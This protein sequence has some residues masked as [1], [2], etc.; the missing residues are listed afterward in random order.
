MNDQLCLSTNNA[1]GS[2]HE[3]IQTDSILGNFAAATPPS[4]VSQTHSPKQ[5][6]KGSRRSFEQATSRL[7]VIQLL[8]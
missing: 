8:P 3:S 2:H 4:T 5:H 1:L 7:T 6:S